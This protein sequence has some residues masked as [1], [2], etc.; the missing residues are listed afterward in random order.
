MATKRDKLY[1]ATTG[2]CY[3]CGCVI[4]YDNFH[5]DHQIP[6]CKGGSSSIVNLVASCCDC[7]MFKGELSVEEFRT[8]INKALTKTI[9]GR[10][11]KQYF[12]IKGKEIIFY[13]EREKKVLMNERKE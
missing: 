9:A 8:K 3:Y 13:G 6:K 12:N 2:R 1:N 5:I 11:I 4:P 7:N 10:M